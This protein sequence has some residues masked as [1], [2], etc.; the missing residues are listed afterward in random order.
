VKPSRSSSIPICAFRTQSEG[1]PSGAALT[2]TNILQFRA[3]MSM[4]FS[5]PACLL[6]SLWPSSRYFIYKVFQ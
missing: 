3:A 6:H 5:V 1:E 2:W 4:Q